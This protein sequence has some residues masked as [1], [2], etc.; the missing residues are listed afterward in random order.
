MATIQTESTTF[1]LGGDLTINRLGYGAMRLT[2]DGIWGDR[3]ERA[4]FNAALGAI[5]KDWKGLQYMSSPNQV[6]AYCR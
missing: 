6:I 5:R 2:G 3:I 4:C 1:E